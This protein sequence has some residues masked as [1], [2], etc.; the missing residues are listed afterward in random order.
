MGDE[1]EVLDHPTP[2]I[3]SL[4]AVTDRPGEPSV[5]VVSACACWGR[6]DVPVSDG[7][8]TIVALNVVLR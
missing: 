6:E 1:N 8:S 4:T 7:S 2:T 5:E 3:P